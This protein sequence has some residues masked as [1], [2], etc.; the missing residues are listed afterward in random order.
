MS[1]WRLML[2]RQKTFE[3]EENLDVM[4]I[5]DKVFQNIK[6]F[7]YLGSILT[8]DNDCS[9]DIKARIAK[10]KGVFAGFNNIWKSKP[11]V[12]CLQCS[13]VCK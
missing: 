4:K 2:K 6:E 10:T 3:E 5:L 9:K 8:W 7:V 12:L 13:F 11:E 1:D